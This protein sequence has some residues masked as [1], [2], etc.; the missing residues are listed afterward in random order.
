MDQGQCD[1]LFRVM[2]TRAAPGSRF[3][4]RQFLTNWTIPEDVRDLY[5]RDSEL[6]ERLT[7]QDSCFIYTFMAGVITHPPQGNYKTPSAADGGAVTSSCA[8]RSS[9]S[10]SGEAGGSS[11]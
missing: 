4:F 5:A 7:R 6:E 11:R 8:T 9:M 2:V 10:M 1:T 3:L